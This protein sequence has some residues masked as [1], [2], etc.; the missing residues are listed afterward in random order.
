M[1]YL[2]DIFFVF[3]VLHTDDNKMIII[4]VVIVVVVVIIAVIAGVILYRQRNAKKDVEGMSFFASIFWPK[5][6]SLQGNNQQNVDA[7]F[8][9]VNLLM[10]FYIYFV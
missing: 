10:C 6:S 7:I 3:V 9:I 8:V 1:K 2:I 4:V 5:S